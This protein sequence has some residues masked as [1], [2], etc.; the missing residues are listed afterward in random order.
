MTLTGM[1]LA[2]EAIRSVRWSD[3]NRSISWWA[4]CSIRGFSRS[5]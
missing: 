2:N 1:G 3:S 5:I 4:R